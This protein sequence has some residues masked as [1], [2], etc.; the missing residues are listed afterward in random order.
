M[1]LHLLKL[2]VGVSGISRLEA[3]QKRRLRKE[4][5]VCHVTRMTPRRAEEILDG[6]SLYWVMAGMIMARQRITAVEPFVDGEGVRRCRLI[7]DP[8]L[9]PVAPQPRKAFQ[10]WRYLNPQDAPPDLTRTRARDEL[11][12]E[13]MRRELGELGLI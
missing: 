9:V 5:R 6:G 10:G 4:G 13:E 8:V 1:A 12:P 3:F 7:L 11:P 2:C